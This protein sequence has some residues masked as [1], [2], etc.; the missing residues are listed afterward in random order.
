MKNKMYKRIAISE[1]GSIVSGATPKTSDATNYGGDIPWLTPADLSGYTNKYIERGA[2]NISKKGYDSCSTQI[3]P[4]GSI[5]FS[6]RAPIGYVAIA[7][8]PICTNQ[9]FKSIVPNK[10]VDSEFLFYQLKFLK[11]QIADLGRGTTFKEISGKTLGSVE[12]VLPDLKEQKRIV[13]EIE[14]LFSELDSAVE[15]L[16]K[17]K[18]Q[19]A[20]YRQSVLKAAFEGRYTELW[21][22][23]QKCNKVQEDFN[24]IYRSTEVFKDIAGDEN[25][26]NLCIPKEWKKVRLGEIFEVC[27]GGTPRRTEST[28]WNGDICW[29]SSGEVKFR[30]IYETE[31]CITEAGVSNSS[32]KVR[33]KGSVLLAMIGEGK[34]R[35]QAALLEVPAAHNQNTASILV[36]E[37][38]C[39]PL[40]LYYFLELNYDHTRRVGSGNNQKALNKDRVKALRMPFCSFE[41]Q[42]QIVSKIES[43]LTVCENIEKTVNDALIQ[44][45]AMRQSILK[46][47]F[48]GEL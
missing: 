12:I 36:S 44:A 18:E 41:E 15:T 6:S 33:P 7:A 38:P 1:I 48:E 39:S 21:R 20:V 5:L 35:G 23:K 29:V 42:K 45:E 14:E 4:A 47:A 28:Y 27:V 26:L 43:H 11:N 24:K 13:S 30:K 8:N 16:K 22:N 9:G 2:R 19:L 25:E 10:N 3:M 17:T 37:T 31:E 34:T 32:A 46:K 40:F